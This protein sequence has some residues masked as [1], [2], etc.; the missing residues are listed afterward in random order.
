LMQ[1]VERRPPIVIEC[2]HFA[3]DDRLVG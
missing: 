3:V 1:D 2:D